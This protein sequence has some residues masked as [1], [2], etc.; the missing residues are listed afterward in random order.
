M[1]GSNPCGYRWITQRIC[2]KTTKCAEQSTL[3]VFTQF[4]VP[5][6]EQSIL[7]IF[8]LLSVPTDEVVVLIVVFDSL[9]WHLRALR[10]IVLCPSF[11]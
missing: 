8:T 10:L 7:H 11:N 2:Y 6:A 4:S 5:T 9:L 3:H 1:I